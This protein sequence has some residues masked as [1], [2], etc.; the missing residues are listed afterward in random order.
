MIQARWLICK[1]GIWYTPPCMCLKIGSTCPNS[2]AFPFQ[3]MFFLV[4]CPSIL[5][6]WGCFRQE[7]KRASLPVSGPSSLETT[8]LR[9]HREMRELSS[10][11]VG[12]LSIFRP[13]SKNS[14]AP[15]FSSYNLPA[16]DPQKTHLGG[17]RQEPALLWMTPD[18]LP[19]LRR[20]QVVD[21]CC[22]YCPALWWLLTCSIS[23]TFL[24]LC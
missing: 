18:L 2:K 7:K 16:P 1:G 12:E 23:P 22:R 11:S 4:S 15:K 10:C 13:T 9:N 3:S 6:D 21:Q 24:L 5:L 17:S 8:N 20:E 19:S 14:L